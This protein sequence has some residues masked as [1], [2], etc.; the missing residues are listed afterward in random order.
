MDKELQAIYKLILKFV[1]LSDFI[2]LFHTW[3][4]FHA[5]IVDYETTCLSSNFKLIREGLNKSVFSNLQ[6]KLAIRDRRG[7]FLKDEDEI[8]QMIWSKFCRI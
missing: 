3:A 6:L 8:S 5:D 2:D 1:S 7:I 4:T